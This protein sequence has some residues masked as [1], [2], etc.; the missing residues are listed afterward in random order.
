VILSETGSAQVPFAEKGSDQGRRPVRSPGR[1]GERE[2]GLPMLDSK[3]VDQHPLDEVRNVMRFFGA[4]L[5]LCRSRPQIIP[6]KLIVER[7]YQVTSVS[8][9]SSISSAIPPGRS[10]RAR[11]AVHGCGAPKKRSRFPHV[12]GKRKNS[13]D[14]VLGSSSL[15]EEFSDHQEPLDILEG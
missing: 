1:G 7:R 2:D 4:P 11:S 8:S 5:Q 9:C 14:H 12:V 15:S 10:D 3:H 13:R 6:G